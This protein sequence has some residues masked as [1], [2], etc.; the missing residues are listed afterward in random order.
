MNI[1]QLRKR[2]AELEEELQAIEQIEQ[3]YAS[4][5]PSSGRASRPAPLSGGGKR[6]RGR[7]NERLGQVVAL[8]AE[9]GKPLCPD[10]IEGRLQEQGAVVAWSDA[11]K[12]LAELARRDRMAQGLLVKHKDGAYGLAE[13]DSQG[14]AE[15]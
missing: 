9:A 1:K 3:T 12:S 11:A 14:S 8:L 2:K 6:P 10:E 13:W 15:Q 4:L 5:Q 7:P